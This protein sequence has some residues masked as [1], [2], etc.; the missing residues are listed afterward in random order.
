MQISAAT[1]RAVASESPVSSTVRSPLRRRIATASAADG[2]I[3]SLTRRNTYTTPE[4]KSLTR[5]KLTKSRKATLSVGA[6][7]LGGN[8]E[9]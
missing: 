2:L 1:A 9:E 8:W 6:T 4:P 3:R 7:G 5:D